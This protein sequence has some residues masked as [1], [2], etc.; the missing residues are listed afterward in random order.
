MTKIATASISSGKL[1]FNLFAEEESSMILVFRAGTY[2][3]LSN[4]EL[5]DKFGKHLCISSSDQES[6]LDYTVEH[7]QHIIDNDK[8]GFLDKVRIVNRLGMKS[9]REFHREPQKP[10]FLS[11]CKKAVDA[12]TD[13]ITLSKESAYALIGLS[14]SDAYPYSHAL[15]VGVLSILVGMNIYGSDKE[16]LWRI[17]L[18]GMTSDIG[19]SLIDE[20]ILSKKT[21]LSE[22]EWEQVKKHPLFSYHILLK[23]DLPESILSAVRS[24]HERVDGSGYPEGLKGKKI[25]PFARILAVTDVYDAITSIKSYG[26]EKSHIQALREMSG[27]HG[28]YDSEV[29]D[30][31]LEVIL[32]NERAISEF[33][34][35]VPRG[36]L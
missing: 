30:S 17:G 34:R 13:L 33:K 8:V 31:L 3:T 18:A 7:I 4:N 21:D 6:Y 1:P 14:S 35:N 23:H 24:H 11:S 20:K 9:I 27:Q 10:D 28:K 12:Y 15:N 25:H 36:K 5:I 19:K 26:E 29:F 22:K 2:I 32:R 16:I